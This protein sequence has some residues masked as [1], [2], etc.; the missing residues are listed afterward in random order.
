MA[1]ALVCLAAGGFARA[2]EYHGQVVFGGV[3]VPGATVT[4]T[5]GDRKI[6]VVSDA[7]GMYRFPDLGDGVWT[8]AVEM[9]CFAP[10][11]QQ[12]TVGTG[13][14]AAK[15]E[16]KLLPLEQI[17]ATATAPPS[18]PLPAAA[19]V[20]AAAPAPAD[21]R[22][23]AKAEAPAAE[24][25]RPPEGAASSQNDGFLINGSATNAATSVFTLAPAFGN[26]RSAKSLYNAQLSL[27]VDSSALDARQFSI[28]GAQTPKA[29]Y[30]NLTAGATFGGPLKIPHLLP[31]GPNFFIQYQTVRNRTEQTLS[32][33]VPTLAE[34]GGD[35]GG[36]ALPASFSVAQALLDYYPCPNV[37]GEYNYQ[38]NAASNTHQDA[39]SLRLNKGIGR[40][41]YLWG[42]F[43]LQSTR[44]DAESLFHFDDTTDFLG[45]RTDVNW[46]HTLH[47]FGQQVFNTASYTF[48]RAR[49]RVV[50]QFAG[51]VN[52]SGEAG[53]AAYPAP[54]GNL[55]DAADW[56]PPTLVFSSGIAALT[57]A[58]SAF[59]R[60]E[61]NSVTDAVLYTHRKHN[62][63]AGVNF[64]RQESNVLSQQNPRGTYTF[65][66][67]GS[68]TGTDF[69]DFLAGVPDNS[70]IAYGNAD[71][72]LREPV[73]GVYVN[74]D[75]RLRPE[76][77]LSVGAR[78]DYEAPVTERKGRLVN[79]ETGVDF[80]S[81]TPVLGSAPGGLPASLVRP[82]RRGVS[83]LV[84]LSWRP[85]PADSLVIKSGYGI[86][87]DTSVYL[88]IAALMD[89]QAPLSTSVN[90]PYN[91][92]TCRLTL[93]VGFL[94]CSS[95]ATP[96]S[97][98]IDPNFRAGY[99]QIWN[100]SV[101]R[102]LPG[103]L[104]ANIT[105]TGT[106][107]TRGTQEFLPNSYPIGGMSPC[108]GC[109][110][111][112]AYRTSNGD[113]TR[114]SVQAQL[115]RRLR[116]GFTATLQYAYSKSIDDDAQLGG[117]GPVAGGATA[118]TLPTATIAQNWL[119]LS[120]ERGL[121]TFDQRQLLNAQVQYTSGMGKAGG[122]LM[123][124]WRGPLLK[125]WTLL[126]SIAA[127][128]GLPE[129]PIYYA[130]TPGT[131][132]A[133]LI[134]PRLT[135]AP[136]YS[137]AAAA[138]HLNAAAYAAPAA[139]Q[140]GDARRDSVTGPGQFSLNGTLQRTFRFKGN[141]N[142]D[143]SV[144]AT[145]LLNHVVYTTWN[146]TINSPTFGLPAATNP[147]RSLQT[148]IRLRY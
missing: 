9:L 78:W 53:I 113:S 26:S 109:A 112:Y 85:V 123:A 41:D 110:A 1:A 93:A 5:Q 98:G 56:G 116:S 18:G 10:L 8:L 24:G 107:G 108:P 83:P 68:V 37:A 74:D 33:L 31:R 121:S 122:T 139:G 92:A 58:E 130:T 101:Q 82:D 118:P 115:R 124:G 52:V 146:T 134:R 51:R 12:V 65:T 57:D 81:V 59:N 73:Y 72:Y 88:P 75:W 69:G 28:T 48:S 22:Q 32:G 45:M 70:A 27:A 144:A 15:L 111:G 148:T 127:G 95:T 62:L 4:A 6:T 143:L 132:Y 42:T 140:W 21:A 67:A 30:D 7:Q 14:A 125:E 13:E 36:S 39:V 25:P 46:Q 119:D 64:R 38:T 137:G 129:T 11:R 84:G 97:F 126:S 142:M 104:V 23:T 106:K 86:Y 120:A 63:S 102:D 100:L 55:Q 44:S 16:L 89:Q 90:E 17:L 47:V 147:M 136:V 29:A 145:N 61:T 114:E 135:G 3:P 103:A 77:T 19:V 40:K 71:K 60:R 80:A 94:P 128:T 96:Y 133:G 79:L 2:A 54:G 50:P 105:Y 43:G 87:R 35:C 34:S 131:G 141:L 117:A 99:A 138:Q 49:T 91:V 20:S 66:T 76:L